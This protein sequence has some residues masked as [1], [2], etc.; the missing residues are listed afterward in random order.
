MTYPE[1]ILQSKPSQSRRRA[2]FTLIELLVVI[3]IIAILAAMLLPALSRA[4]ARSKMISCVSNLKQLDLCWVMYLGDFGEKLL[5]NSTSG[6][7]DSWIK[8]NMKNSASDATNTVYLE[9]ALL[10]SY[11]K[12]TGIYVCPA[13][14]KSYYW[15]QV[16]PVRSY[17]L[18]FQMGGNDN[19]GTPPN[20]WP[21]SLKSSS[22]LHPPPS[23]ANT[24]VCESDYTIDDGVFAVSD[25]QPSLTSPN[26]WQNAPS[27]RHLTGGTFAFADGH[28]EFWKYLEPTT[29]R[30][31]T[32][33]WTSPFSP[34][35]D[36]VRLIMATHTP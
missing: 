21:V 1:I 11:N 5:P 35:R 20:A 13:Q 10:Y 7:A 28:A 29:V 26:F 19:T 15:P 32:R 12:N 18:N 16:I 36:L 31:S 23:Q 25:I 14:G 27:N 3:A 30:I 9:Q 33:N 6:G 24:F 8:G 2:A 22:I 34:D 4:K 17:S